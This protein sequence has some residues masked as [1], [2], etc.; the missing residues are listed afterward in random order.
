V[1]K[2]AMSELLFALGGTAALQRSGD[3]CA[4]SLTAPHNLLQPLQGTVKRVCC[5]SP[6]EQSA[7]GIGALA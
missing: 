5:R 3:R 6:D 7:G 4:C 1:N 2:W